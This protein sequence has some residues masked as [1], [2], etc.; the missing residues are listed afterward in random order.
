MANDKKSKDSRVP[1]AVPT[2]ASPS[3][4]ADMKFAP[5]ASRYFKGAAA[6][7]FQQLGGHEFF[8][9]LAEDNPEFFVEKVLGKI[10]DNEARK[11]AAQEDKED[12][13]SLMAKL[14]KS[15]KLID[16]DAEDLADKDEDGDES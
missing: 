7:A 6:L 12:V 1:V 13:E 4:S 14:K 10:M 8:V 5:I 11:Q 16:V 9:R 15:G 2:Y 3:I